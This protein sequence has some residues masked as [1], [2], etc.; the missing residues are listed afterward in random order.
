MPIAQHIPCANL[1]VIL[2][3]IYVLYLTSV[4]QVSGPPLLFHLMNVLAFMY[5]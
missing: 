1:G 2:V 5:L 3:P 4:L